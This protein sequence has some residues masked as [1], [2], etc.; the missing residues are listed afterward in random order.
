MRRTHRLSTLLTTIA[1]MIGGLQVLSGP[2]AAAATPCSVGKVFNVV[3]HHDDDL[4]FLTP[5][6]LGDLANPDVCVRAV[7]LIASYY[8]G[9][10]RSTESELLDYVHERELGV[11]EAYQ[12]AAGDTTHNWT[13]SAY[14]AGGL[15]STLWSL[16]DRVSIAEVRIPDNASP[17]RQG[18]LWDLY[19]DN[20]PTETIAGEASPSQTVDRNKVVSFL[21]GAIGDFGPTVVNTEDPTADTRDDRDFHPDHVATTRLLMTALHQVSVPR[22]TY[23]RDYT[24]KDSPENLDAATAAYKWDVFKTFAV[25]DMDICPDPD[26]PSC[27]DSW[28]EHRARQYYADAAWRGNL[29]LPLPVATVQPH[30]DGRYK[31]INRGTGQNLDVNGGSVDD[32]APIITWP[33]TGEDNQTFVLRA[34]QGGWMLVAAHSGR[35]VDVPHSATG[36]IDLIQY[37]CS[38]NSNQAFRLRGDPASGYVLTAS[39]STL[40]ITGPTGAGGAVTQQPVSAGQARQHWDIVPAP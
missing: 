7:F 22:V 9:A 33:A 12:Q 5:D 27:P 3:A 36:P 30:M 18:Q 23:Y 16:G 15:T 1:L 32:L 2:V 29:V 13:P 24:S 38:G 31:L 34:A 17:V 21:T 39:N 4:L 14:T 8:T 19:A 40:A 20:S 35:C 28:T 37:E 10:G 26:A 11:R 6:L 25:H